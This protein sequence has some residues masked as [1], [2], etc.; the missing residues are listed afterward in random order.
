MAEDYQK[1]HAGKELALEAR[2]SEAER[3]SSPS[4][5]RNRDAIRDVFCDHM[6][7][8]GTVLEIGSGTGEHAVH[9]SR[10]LPDLTW[11]PSDPD[12]A[13]RRSIIAWADYLNLT[14]VHA[15]L[16]LDVAHADWFKRPDIP[17]PLIGMMSVNMIHIA[18]FE[19][20]EGLFAGAGALLQKEGRLFLY[21]PFL[22]EGKTAPSNHAFDES[23]RSRDPRWGVRDLDRDILPL[24]RRAGLSL[25][26]VIQMPANNLAVIF[27]RE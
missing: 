12:A 5:A 13:S 18:P 8:M 9:I 20:A 15:P 27:S 2:A 3:L 1:D 7:D 17:T 14:N 25:Q 22:R 4:V 16:D 21:G 23:L 26:K 6:P 19:A 10:R 11:T 24:A